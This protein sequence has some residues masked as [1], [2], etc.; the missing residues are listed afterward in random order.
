[1]FSL[2]FLSY[3]AYHAARKP[4]SVVKNVLNRNC[5]GLVPPDDIDPEDRDTWCQWEPFGE[6]IL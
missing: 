1:M 2:T 5:S 4:V 3:I 6:S